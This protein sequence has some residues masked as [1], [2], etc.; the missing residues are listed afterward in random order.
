MPG[1]N[2]YSDQTTTST[3]VV[4][5]GSLVTTAAQTTAINTAIAGIVPDQQ[6]STTLYTGALSGTPTNATSGNTTIGTITTINSIANKL[7]TLF[8]P[9][10]VTPTSGSTIVS[11]LVQLTGAALTN[12]ISASFDSL[13][14]G[15]DTVV[16]KD[17]ST[18]ATSNQLALTFGPN[19]TGVH[20][21]IIRVVAVHA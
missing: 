1:S 13:K 7:C 20:T 18:N 8:I 9:V 14:T 17:V 21:G 5:F 11:L 15:S 10:S 19:T 4:T 3:G 12:V 16:M 2:L 6:V